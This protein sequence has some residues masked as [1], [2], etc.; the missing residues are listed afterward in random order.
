MTPP[1]CL[2]LWL[3]ERNYQLKNDNGTL[4]G[5]YG[6]VIR[7]MPIGPPSYGPQCKY[8]APA[9]NPVAAQ[10]R[11]WAIVGSSFDPGK[12]RLRAQAALGGGDPLGFNAADFETTLTSKDE[13]LV[14]AAGSL[15]DVNQALMFRRA[16]PSPGGAR[17][18]LEIAL[19]KIN[20]GGCLE[21]MGGTLL[22][23][24][25]RTQVCELR[26]EIVKLAGRYVSLS[27]EHVAQFD[28]VPNTFPKDGA[29]GFRRQSGA[30]FVFTAQHEKQ[31]LTG[32][33]MAYEEGGAWR[34]VFLWA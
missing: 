1:G 23:E 6:N 21:V 13:A 30:V 3:E 27:V 29:N 20:T 18:A 14:D 28:R 9:A 5:S 33:A 8:D 16:G 10:Y 34:I 32:N 2:R 22:P 24:A 12:W 11:S 4:T 7:A 17:E 31:A 19:R 25:V 15:D 26:Q